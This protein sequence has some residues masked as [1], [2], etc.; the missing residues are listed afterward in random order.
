MAQLIGSYLCGTDS[1]AMFVVGAGGHVI[2]RYGMNLQ[3]LLTRPTAVA[4]AKQLAP[5]PGLAALGAN[6][7]IEALVKE[8]FIAR[9]LQPQE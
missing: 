8:A 7:G 5:T 6:A 4:I 3:Q 2:T 1:A 9:R